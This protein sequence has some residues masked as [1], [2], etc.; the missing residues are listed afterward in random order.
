[1]NFLGDNT[2]TMYGSYDESNIYKIGKA[3]MIIDYQDNC[4][5]TISYPETGIE[6]IDEKVLFYANRLRDNFLMQYKSGDVSNGTSYGMHVEYE[7][8]LE[9]GDN[10][11]LIFIDTITEN[12]DTIISKN[13]YTHLFSILTGEELYNSDKAIGDFANIEDYSN[14]TSEETDQLELLYSDDIIKFATTNLN[15]RSQRSTSSEKLGTLY[16][17][18]AIEVKS[19]DKDWETVIYNGNIAYIKTGYLTKKKVLHAPIE[20]EVVDR[21]IDPSKPML[22]LTFDDGPSPYSTP[23]ILD[24]LEKNGVVATFFDLG[25]LVNTYPDI[26]RREEQI[27]C[28][29]GS[30]TY[31]HKNL[32]TLSDAQIK[33]EITK[34]ENAFIKALG[35]KTTLVRPPYGNANLKVKENIDYPLIDWNVDSLDWKLRDKNKIIQ[36]VRQT[37][38]F[39]GHI[40]LMHSIYETTAAAVEELIPQLLN[41]GYQFVTV[42]ELAFYK[43]N[44]VLYTAIDYHGF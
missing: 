33:E 20:I 21:G 44:T 18:E 14:Y 7:T 31:S 30:H 39:D 1:M 16:E 8:S 10:F 13:E 15:I 37:G 12:E 19:S 3:Q 23:R 34:S 5:W 4:N 28:E 27:G 2:P 11:C 6:E 24:A 41:E 26:V 22:A 40:I 32:N 25:Q 9:S 17:G 38:N 43:G 29:I 42:S 36:R 35:H